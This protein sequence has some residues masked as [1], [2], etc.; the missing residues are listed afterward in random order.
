MHIDRI[1]RSVPT[2][3]E[4]EYDGS[5]RRFKFRGVIPGISHYDRL[6]GAIDWLE[7]A[8]LIVKI[9]SLNT[10]RIP[11]YG[12]IRKS[13]FKLFLFDIG[14]LGAMVHLDPKTILDYQ[15]GSYKGYFAEVFVAQEMIGYQNESLF[16]WQEKQYELEFIQEYEGKLVPIEVKSAQNTKASSLKKFIQKYHPKEQILMSSALP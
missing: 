5:T 8:G 15:Y 6:S 11:L 16:S 1:L 2:Q 14:L 4:K 10:A 9:H 13:F 12:Y 3:L 7:S